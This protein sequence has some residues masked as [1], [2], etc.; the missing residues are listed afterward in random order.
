MIQHFWTIL[1]GRCIL[2]HATYTASLID[3]LEEV[4]FFGT[5]PA[6]QAQL[7]V[8]WNLVTLWR[9]AEDNAPCRGRARVE[10]VSP[11]GQV[12]N[13]HQIEYE[14]D[15]VANS[16]ARGVGNI[17]LLPLFPEGGEYRFRILL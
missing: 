5:I 10:V 4:V 2:E 15:L 14:I 8:N 13:P 11:S 6:G 3:I 9:R 16:R 17:Q 12:V 7:T 1:C